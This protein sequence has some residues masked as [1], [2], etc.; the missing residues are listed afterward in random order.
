MAERKPAK[1]GTQNSAKC[2]TKKAVKMAAPRPGPRADKADGESA[3]LVNIAAMPGPY[4]AM[5]ERMN[6][7]MLGH[8][9]A[10]M[11]SHQG[12]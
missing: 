1:K 11:C 6:S 12:A 2:I 3:V 5:S 9:T 10:L 4:R 7:S 8:R